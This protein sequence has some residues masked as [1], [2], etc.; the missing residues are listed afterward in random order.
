MD[1][2][3]VTY[4]GSVAPSVSGGRPPGHFPDTRSRRGTHLSA[5]RSPCRHRRGRRCGRERPGRRRQ[6]NPDVQPAEDHDRPQREDHHGGRR[7]AIRGREHRHDD[8]RGDPR[9]PDTDSPAPGRDTCQVYA[10]VDSPTFDPNQITPYGSIVFDA[11][12]NRGVSEAQTTLAPGQYVAFDTAVAAVDQTAFTI[13]RAANPGRPADTAGN[14]QHDR[15]RVP[16][17]RRAT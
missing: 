2:T 9:Q 15:L 11:Q 13:T 12:A 4:A 8:H 10:V 7:A 14:D 1:V 6:R 17:R 5:P 16:R 3:N